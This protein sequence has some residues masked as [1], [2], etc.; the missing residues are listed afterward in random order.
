MVYCYAMITRVIWLRPAVPIAPTTRP[1]SSAILRQGDE[2]VG[3]DGDRRSADAHSRRRD[4]ELRQLAG[5]SRHGCCEAGS[6]AS[7]DVSC[8]Y[9]RVSSG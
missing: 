7:W 6:R 3:P 1:R 5:R 4:Q 2:L 9:T 8:S